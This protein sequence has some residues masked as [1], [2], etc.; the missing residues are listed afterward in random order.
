MGVL[1]REPGELGKLDGR[2][3]A[4]I[5]G[6]GQLEGCQG[7]GLAQGRTIPDPGSQSDGRPLLA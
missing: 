2:S 1:G 7:C 3:P 4:V 6:G 5:I